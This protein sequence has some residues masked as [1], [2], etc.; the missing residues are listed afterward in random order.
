M[1]VIYTYTH[2]HTHI[3]ENITTQNINAFLKRYEYGTGMFWELFRGSGR[4]KL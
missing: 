2:T 1:D 4:G 3:Q